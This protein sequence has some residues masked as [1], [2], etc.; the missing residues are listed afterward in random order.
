M[1]KLDKG[2]ANV[3]TFGAADQL[4]VVAILELSLVLGSTRTKKELNQAFFEFGFSQISGDFVEI[5]L[6]IVLKIRRPR[7][8][9]V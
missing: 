6:K 7:L 2:Q 3:D 1:I 8:D 5:A 4:G 9:A